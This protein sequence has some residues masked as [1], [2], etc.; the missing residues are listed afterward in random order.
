[1]CNVAGGY[2]KMIGIAQSY[3]AKLSANEHAD[4]WGNNAIAFYR[5]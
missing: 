5:L 4:F 3:T 2:D 1:V